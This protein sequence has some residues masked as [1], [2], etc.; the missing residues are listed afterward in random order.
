MKINVSNLY[1]YVEQWHDTYHMHVVMQDMQMHYTLR[2]ITFINIHIHI[3]I[4]VVVNTL[5]IYIVNSLTICMMNTLMNAFINTY[6]SYVSSPTLT[7][8]GPSQPERADSAAGCPCTPA[9]ARR[10]AFPDS[11]SSPGLCLQRVSASA[12]SS[13]KLFLQPAFPA[14]LLT[15]PVSPALE[16]PLEPVPFSL[17]RHSAPGPAG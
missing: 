10:I 13:S 14:R 3:F 15:Q 1:C 9:D 11:V 4:N 16:L 7:G 5:I 6:L 2:Y 12:S 17:Q 8:P